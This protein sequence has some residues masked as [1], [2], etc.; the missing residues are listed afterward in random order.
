LAQ[1]SPALQS[2]GVAVDRLIAKAAAAT[3]VRV[4]VTLRGAT[5]DPGS[6]PLPSASTRQPAA[7]AATTGPLGDGQTATAEQAQ[8]IANH[9]GSDD[10]K[11]RRWGPRLIHN[12]PYMAMR[13]SLS[14]LEA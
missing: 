9:V 6:A 8:V 1:G 10:A 2:K 4:I 14:E 12:M 13:V 7:P 3:G 11:R 5:A